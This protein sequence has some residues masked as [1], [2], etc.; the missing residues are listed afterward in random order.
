[1]TRE[2]TPLDVIEG[3]ARWCVVCGERDEVLA[4]L[5]DAAVDVTITDPP[6]NVNYSGAGKETSNTIMNDHMDADEF[7]EFLNDVF[8]CM[9][10]AT[11]DNAPAYVCYASREHRAFGHHSQAAF[12]G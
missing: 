6:Y 11:V 8:R 5:G 1:M 4:S 3:R 10:E 12:A 2:A 7:A 9:K